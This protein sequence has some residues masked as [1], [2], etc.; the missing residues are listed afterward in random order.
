MRRG[1]EAVLGRSD[2]TRRGFTAR[3]GEGGAG[4][5]PARGVKSGSA[6]AS[7]AGTGGGGNS[8]SFLVV[9]F[10]GARSRSVDR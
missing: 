5:P 8:A 1:T 9:V 3:D 10:F 7:P 2:A 4:P 6:T